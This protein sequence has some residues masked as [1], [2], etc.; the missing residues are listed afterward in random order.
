MP[1]PPPG[2]TTSSTRRTSYD[3]K[4]TLG[5]LGAF[6]H[7]SSLLRG[8]C[9]CV[10]HLNRCK[11]CTFVCGP[12]ADAILLNPFNLQGAGGR[13]D[14][15]GQRRPIYVAGQTYLHFFHLLSWDAANPR[16]TVP[17]S[18]ICFFNQ[19][20]RTFKLSELF[21]DTMSCSFR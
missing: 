18:T 15:T 3:G 14:G 19:R 21:S 16:T 7:K 20:S 10:T 9:V 4:T 11:T 6:F 2:E 8:V 12:L 5:E 1:H 17:T 13:I